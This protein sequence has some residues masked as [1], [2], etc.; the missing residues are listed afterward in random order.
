MSNGILDIETALRLKGFHFRT[1]SKVRGYKAGIH[2]SYYNGI[3]TD[4]LDHKEYNKGD[5][6]KQIDWRLYG[7]HDRLY[8]KKFEDEVNMRWCIFIDKS[9]S[10]GYGENKSTKLNYAKKL[11]A[12]L[13]YLLLKQGDSV[14]LLGFSE[15]GIEFIPPKAGSSFITPIVDKLESFKPSGTT[16][17]K[18]PV[19]KALEAYSSEASFV[20][21]S[22]FLIEPEAIEESL[23]LIRNSRKE[24]SLFH[25]LHPDEIDFDF[26]GSVEFEDM[27]TNAKVIVDTGSIR[28]TYK[29]RM[30]EFI[31]RLKQICHENETRYVFSPINKSIENSLIQIA[32]K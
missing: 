5:E 30:G 16:G 3:S 20:I 23:K 21:V 28:H 24:V 6:L 25:V 32:D 4:F 29:K 14:G 1:P 7:R 13:A 19:L 18:E 17:I 8:V 31:E 27:E 26:R 10:M 2:K 9:A 11:S 15:K 22:D 12:T